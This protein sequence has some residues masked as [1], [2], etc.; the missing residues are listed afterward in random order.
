M[1]FLWVWVCV[2]GEEEERGPQAQDFTRYAD[3]PN[4]NCLRIQQDFQGENGNGEGEN[5]C[6]NSTRFIST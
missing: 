5:S 6:F 2:G 3:I 1:F 4:G